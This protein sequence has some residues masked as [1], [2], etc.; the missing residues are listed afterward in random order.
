MQMRQVLQKTNSDR[1][2]IAST[3][4]LL[5]PRPF[6]APF[7]VEETAPSINSSGFGNPLKISTLLGSRQPSPSVQPKL[8]I[9]EPGDQYEQEADRVAA[10][11]VQ[12]MNAPADSRSLDESK[13]SNEPIQRSLKS[14]AQK[15]NQG[16]SP[17]IQRYQEFRNHIRRQLL[18]GD[19]A[20]QA[21]FENRLN[22]ARQ[23]GSPLDKTLRSKVEPLMGAD[24]SGVKVH[25]DAQVD[26]LSRS[27][28]AKAFTT[29]QDVFF[30]QGAYEPGSRGGQELIAH[31]LTNVTQQSGKEVQR[32]SL[33]LRR[34]LQPSASVNPS[35]DRP[36]QT[37]DEMTSDR[38]VPSEPQPPN[39]T[40]LPDQL[41]TGIEQL[42]GYSI[43]DVRVHY[44]SDKPMQF[45]ALAYAQGTDIH[46]T[47]GQEKLLPHE[48]WHIVQQKQGRVQPTTRLKG[49]QINDNLSLEHEADVMGAKVVSIMGNITALPSGKATKKV[50]ASTHKVMQREWSRESLL[51]PNERQQIEALIDM[52]DLIEAF[53][54]FIE[55]EL[56]LS[57][58]FRQIVVQ[59]DHEGLGYDIHSTLKNTLC[60]SCK[61]STEKVVELM[62]YGSAELPQE[63]TESDKNDHGN[64]SDA[65]LENIESKEELELKDFSDPSEMQA[66]L[67]EIFDNLLS[68]DSINISQEAKNELYTEWLEKGVVTRQWWKTNRQIL[69]Q[70]F[71]NPIGKNTSESE[72]D[73]ESSV[74]MKRTG[75]TESHQKKYKTRNFGS[76]EE[77]IYMRD[78]QGNIDFSKAKNFKT[79]SDPLDSSSK[80]VELNKGMKDKKYG[81]MGGGKKVKITKASRAQHF[82]MGDKLLGI[83]ESYRR[84]KWTW[85]HLS[86]QYEMVLVDM[87]VHQKHG[88]N[89][90]IMLWT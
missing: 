86:D 31:E 77:V 23:S 29:G 21:D 56:I 4:K 88:H 48:A 42:S 30:R 78:G 73:I 38:P 14:I 66:V 67:W 74:Q 63:Y 22:Q 44:N 20:P 83:K 72:M 51:S 71:Y 79:W 40:G 49:E 27:I 1:S 43:D 3:A 61:F 54:K 81:I 5:E 10:E 11:V 17:P 69:A 46:I 12:Q 8:T 62:M 7:P 19:P 18:A 6:A 34:L 24:F 84:G 25:T 2:S 35:V 28:Q 37:K 33:P 41:K 47:P 15:A 70:K 85:H 87:T 55:D 76:F 59:I 50:S 26:Q 82:S 65:T 13:N 75:N 89:G 57:E 16:S 60:S 9:G 53:Q 52:G 90:G 32:S 45:Q 68:L 64:N 39:K 36:L 58:R 80:K